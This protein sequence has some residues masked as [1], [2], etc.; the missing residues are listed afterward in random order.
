[1]TISHQ[2]FRRLL[3][4]AL[5]GIPV[6]EKG[7]RFTVE[8]E[9]GEVTILL[10]PE[11]VRKLASLALPRTLVSIDLSSHSQEQAEKFIRRF[12]LAYQKGGG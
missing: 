11:E 9:N 1:M 5:G 6:A 12:D 7:Q 8:T 3:P 10:G 2:D 4:K